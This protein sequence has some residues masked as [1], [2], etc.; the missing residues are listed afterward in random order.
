MLGV[1]YK[2]H[3]SNQRFFKTRYN[4]LA[5]SIISLFVLLGEIEKKHQ[6]RPD[7]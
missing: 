1:V 2:F 7:I 3:F 4:L 6:K 5:C